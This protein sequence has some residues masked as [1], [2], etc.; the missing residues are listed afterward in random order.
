MR[1]DARQLMILAGASVVVALASASGQS[2]WIDEANT[3]IRAMQPDFESF[4]KSLWGVGGSDAHMPLYMAWAWLWEKLFGHSEMALRLA[5]LPWLLTAVGLLHLCGR[6]VP[7]LRWAPWLALLHPFVWAYFNEARPYIMQFSGACLML[8]LP[9]SL[10]SGAARSA[11][12]GR[13][14]W[15]FALGLVLVTGASVLGAPFAVTALGVVLVMLW[16]GGW[17][18]GAALRP[19]LAAGLGL[20]ALLGV[21]FL[22]VMATGARASNDAHTSAG[23]LLFAVYE[24]LGFSGWGPGRNELRSGSVSVLLP[25]L[26]GLLLLAGAYGLLVWSGVRGMAGAGREAWRPLAGIF[27]SV[28]PAVLAVALAGIAMHFRIL[29][30]HFTPVLPCV[31]LMLALLTGAAWNRGGR[32]GRVAAG[33]LM[34]LLLG[35]ALELRFGPRHARDDYRSA[36]A[37]ALQTGGRGWWLADRAGAVYYGLPDDG[38]RYHPLRAGINVDAD[39]LP[40]WIVLSKPDIYDPS[41]W[42]RAKIVRDRYVL[43]GRVEAFELYRRP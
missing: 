13:Y 35:S 10:A 38:V 17:K 4:L 16:R 40:D 37:F 27:G 1:A 23:S 22:F 41:G 12:E 36:A 5:N 42:V 31:L 15:L 39:E 29:G 11:D 3:A 43:A 18:G 20:L 9:V 30:R 14:G 2:L 8:P 24:L 7:S 26:P 21:H 19:P 34:L 28:I 6:M 32:T 25:Y 33:L